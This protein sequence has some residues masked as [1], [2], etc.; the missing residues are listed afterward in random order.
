MHTHNLYILIILIFFWSFVFLGLHMWHVKVPMLGVETEQLLLAHA[1]AK[2]IPDLAASA[3]CT[4]AHA[5]PDP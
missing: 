1:R 3:T 2:A 4:T 5:A